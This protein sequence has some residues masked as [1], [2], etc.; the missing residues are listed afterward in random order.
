MI[1]AFELKNTRCRCC[2]KIPYFVKNTFLI[3]CLVLIVFVNYLVDYEN[4]DLSVKSMQKWIS[5]VNS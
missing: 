2:Y 1:T 5:G 4:A 3:G